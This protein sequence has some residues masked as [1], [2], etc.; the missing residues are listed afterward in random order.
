MQGVSSDALGFLIFNNL[1]EGVYDNFIVQLNGCSSTASGPF[2][3]TDPTPPNLPNISSNSGICVGQTLNLFASSTSAGLATYQWTGPNGF[4]S[5]EQNPTIPSAD[6]NNSGI[7]SVSVTITNCTSALAST[8]VIINPPATL[9]LVI[10]PISYCINTTA[11]SLTA[12]NNTGHTLNW[13]TA[14]TGGLPL[15]AAPVPS[16]TATGTTAYYVSQTT[17]NGCEG[18]RAQIAV[19]IR[20]DAIASFIPVDTM[21][22]APFSITSSDVGLQEFPSNNSAYNWYSND[23]FIGSGTIF[24]G[25]SILNAGDSVTIKL[26]AVSAFGCRNDSM[27]RK[28]Y[29]IKIPIPSF[30]VSDSVGCG[31]LSVNIV[32]TSNNINSYNIKINFFPI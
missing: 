17:P 30:T 3:L 27:E 16:T 32:N 26:V 8:S 2:N 7:Y 31:P 1:S 9:P 28:F 10:S 13:Y 25:Y 6:A 5:I 14:P 15:N 18:P 11:M 22:C 24:P 4:N 12:T 23:I 21:K 20:P 19:I 29:T